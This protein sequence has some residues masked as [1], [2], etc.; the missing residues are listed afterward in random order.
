VAGLSFRLGLQPPQIRK[1]HLEVVRGNVGY[2]RQV[3]GAQKTRACEQEN[4]DP[5]LPSAE[6][7]FLVLL[8]SSF[9]KS[10]FLLDGIN[11]RPGMLRLQGADGATQDNN[12]LE[13]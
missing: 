2:N 6:S 13:W 4:Y 12:G 3:Q 1:A 9:S 10:L 11:P 5:K 7:S 8:P